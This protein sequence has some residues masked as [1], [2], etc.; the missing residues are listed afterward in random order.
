VFFRWPCGLSSARDSSAVHQHLHHLLDNPRQ[1]I[2][3]PPHLMDSRTTVKRHLTRESVQKIGWVISTAEVEG[4][5]G[6]ITKKHNWHAF[7]DMCWPLGRGCQ[8]GS[9]AGSKETIIRFFEKRES[10]SAP[11]P[12]IGVERVIGQ[13]LQRHI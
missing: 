10:H 3:V 5:K 8:Q 12:A 9:T 1:I 7:M 6:Q 4:M 2:L 11:Y 13:T